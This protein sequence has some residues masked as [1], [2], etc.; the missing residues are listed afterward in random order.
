MKKFALALLAVAALTG[1]ATAQA[2]LQITEIWPGNEPGDNLSEDWF[3]I[4]NMGDAT[5]DVSVDGDLWYDDES[6]DP[7]DAVKL[8]GI[9]IIAPGE[10]V[11]YVDE[12]DTGGWSDLWDDVITLPQVGGYDGKGLGQG[13]DGVAIWFGSASG[14]TDLYETYPDADS[15]GGQSYDVVLEEFSTVG[16]AS[17]AVATLVVNDEGQAAIGSP[18]SIP[19]PA[20]MSVLALGGIAA[21]IRRRRR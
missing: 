13:G 4:T 15:Y 18:G 16:N 12:N 21:V 20:T 5:W 7:L 10:S 8:T 19:E 9:S 3:E 14:A 11:I 17:G 2:N 6:A 1:M